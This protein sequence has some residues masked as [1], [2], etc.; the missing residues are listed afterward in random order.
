MQTACGQGSISRGMLLKYP[1][2]AWRVHNALGVPKLT[3]R[4]G[5]CRTVGLRLSGNLLE[6]RW[7]QKN[8]E[9]MSGWPGTE[10][11]VKSTT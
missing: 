11:K 5:G 3:S 4:P 2:V 8:H 6:P 9:F 10:R 1:T 7:M